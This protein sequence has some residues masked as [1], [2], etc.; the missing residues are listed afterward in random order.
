M[1]VVS[2]GLLRKY[3]IALLCLW[4]TGVIGLILFS[5]SLSDNHLIYTLDDPYIHLAVAESI[6][7]GNY[8]INADEY[9]APSSSII[10][11]FLLAF[12]QWL[13][14]GIWGPLAI[15]ILSMA[16][17]IYVVGH[18]IQNYVLARNGH[19]GKSILS[20]SFMI[21][22]GLFACLILN[23]WGLVMTG[24]EH[25]LHVFAVILVVLGFLR[26]HDSNSKAPFWLIAAIAALP[27]IRFEG[28]AMALLSIAALIYLRQ[29]LAAL[30]AA[31]LL[32][33]TLFGWIWFTQSHGLPALPSSVLLKSSIAA[34]VE[35]Q[36]GLLKLVSSILKNGRKSLLDRQGSL[37]L[38]GILAISLLSYQAWKKIGVRHQTYFVIGA[39]TVLTG[40]A[41][42]FF[43]QYGWFSRY[44]I[45]AFA[46][47]LVSGLILGGSYFSNSIVR[48]SVICSLPIVAAPYIIDTIRTPLASRNIYQQQYQM[49]RFAVE[50]WRRPIAVNDLGWVSYKNSSFVLDLWGLGSEEVRLLKLTKKGLD[51]QKLDS[52]ITHR[53]IQL[54]MIYDEWFDGI[55]PNSWQKIAILNTSK[56]TAAS[57]NVSFYIT[58]NSSRQEVIKLLQSF[59]K[60]LPIGAFLTIT[61]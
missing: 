8:G 27:L 12:T 15:N 61:P 9:S 51:T 7:Q 53:N 29:W 3:P 22:L 50:Y 40:L 23:A 16:A 42:V 21:T 17:A 34:N 54:I 18:I 20:N 36:S 6:L 38:L 2:N 5:V 60:T 55:I 30:I 4:L 41:H 39:L 13:G 10:Y 32:L 14:F 28:L 35:G 37:L 11:P 1:S 57:E 46:L 31:S 49:H 52:L 33:V 19:G 25:S 24:M 43:G 26:L 47:I 59:E 58:P 45:Y 44:E 48:I 56:V